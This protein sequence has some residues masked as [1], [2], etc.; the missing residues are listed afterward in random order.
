MTI[1]KKQALETLTKTRLIEVADERGLPSLMRK[2]KDEVFEP[3]A[4]S[5]AA[6]LPEL[7]A[8]FSR[9]E[10]KSAREAVGLSTNPPLC[11]SDWRGELLK[12]DQRRAYS[13]PSGGNANDAWVRQIVRLRASSVILA[14]RVMRGLGGV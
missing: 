2:H 12:D 6:T 8:P 4:S 10:L 9:A 5:R 7:L 1:T 14:A 11:D 3:V 13:T